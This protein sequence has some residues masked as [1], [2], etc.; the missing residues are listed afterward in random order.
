MMTATL[1]AQMMKAIQY[2]KPNLKP[3]SAEADSALLRRVYQQLQ[4]DFMPGPLFL[5][6]SP[7]PKLMAAVW[8]LLRETLL[9]GT[10]DRVKKEV[11]AAT[12]SQINACPFCVDAHT[13]MLHATGHHAVVDALLRGETPSHDPQLAALVQWTWANRLAPP[14]PLPPPFAPNDAP[15]LLGTVF[16]FHYLNRMANVFLGDSFLPLPTVLKGLTRRVVGATI[17]KSMVRSLPAGSSLSFVPAAPLP[18]DL[19]WA[20]P[21]KVVS[22]ALAGFSNVVEEAGL[23]TLSTPVRLLAHQYLQRWQGAAPGLSRRWVEDAIGDLPERE[24]SA[25][26]LVLLTALAAYQVD[27][28]SIAAFRTHYP[29]DQQLIEV[30]AW[31]SWLAAR[32]ATSWF[33]GSSTVTA[34]EM[35]KAE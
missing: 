11:V 19:A 30:T 18:A 10:V 17:G 23:A 35:E 1:N 31:A 33:A 21:N 3:G 25:A 6:H 27:A 12:I 22:S 28:A 15:E 34:V 2:V 8:S 24:R 32:R 5:L 20:Q 16:A 29:T 7:A 14:T 26:R 13:T 9:A 4:A